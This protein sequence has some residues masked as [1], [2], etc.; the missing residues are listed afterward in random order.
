MIFLKIYWKLDGLI[1]GQ[2]LMEATFF[3]MVFWA[4]AKN[5]I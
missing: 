1:K 4:F 3:N 5:L 2:N